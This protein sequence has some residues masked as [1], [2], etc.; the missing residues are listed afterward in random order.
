MTRQ[1]TRRVIDWGGAR[2]WVPSLLRRGYL[3][4][5][6]PHQTGHDKFFQ[7]IPW[8]EIW[9]S[10]S[11]ATHRSCFRADLDVA[12]STRT[13]HCTG[14]LFALGSTSSRSTSN[15]T[16]VLSTPAHAP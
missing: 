2:P 10:C 14:L 6:E 4:S 9:T 3:R 1:A 13:A 12:D 5:V 15:I 8:S 7:K 16:G 11:G